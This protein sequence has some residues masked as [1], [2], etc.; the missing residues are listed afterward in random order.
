MEAGWRSGP[1]HRVTAPS[2]TPE[3]WR[4]GV[5]G[6]SKSNAGRVLRYVGLVVEGI[7]IGTVLLCAP[8]LETRT[9]LDPDPLHVDTAA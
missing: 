8:C 7:H 1:R 2:R 3:C 6:R 4:C 9:P 5:E